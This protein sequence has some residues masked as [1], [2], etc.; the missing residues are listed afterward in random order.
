MATQVF[1]GLMVLIERIQQ[2]FPDLG[3]QKVEQVIQM[4]CD[5]QQLKVLDPQASP[6][7]QLICYVPT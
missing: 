1:I 5:E 6:Q 4:L 3:E 7:A 2:Q